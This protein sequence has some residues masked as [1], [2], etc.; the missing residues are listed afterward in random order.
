MLAAGLLV[1][2]GVRFYFFT[3]TGGAVTS[4][5]PAQ[6]AL[7]TALL[8]GATI[9]AVHFGDGLDGPSPRPTTSGH[10]RRAPTSRSGSSADMTTKA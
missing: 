6:G 7:L 9:N 10:S 1:A 4:M 3:S 8:V 5:D 2:F